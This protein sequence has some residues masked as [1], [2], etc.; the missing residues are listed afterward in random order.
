[1][2]EEALER[3]RIA[4]IVSDGFAHHGYLPVETPLIEDRMSLERVSPVADSPFQLFDGDGRLLMVRSDLTMPIARMVA[5]RFS[6]EQAP[7]RLRYAAPVVRECAQNM[8]RSRQFTQLGIELIGEA[9][10]A[11][12]VE[13]VSLAAESLMKLGLEDFCIACGSVKPMK[14]LLDLCVPDMAAQKSLLACIHASDFIDFEA[15]LDELGL[16]TAQRDALARLPRMCGGVEELDAAALLLA[17]FGIEDGG[18]AEL[19]ELFAQAQASGFADRLM[20]DFSIMNSFDYYTGLVFSIYAEGA[21]DS[22]GSGGRYDEAFSKLGL[23]TLPAAGFA[24]SLESIEEALLGAAALSRPLRI[25]VP[26]GSLFR[27]TVDLLAAAGFDVEPLRN[28]GRHLIV[29]AE[30][31]EYVIVRPTDAPAF[32]ASGGADCGICGR[33]SL[34]EANLD[35][36]QLLDLGYGTCRFVVAEPSDAAGRA[37][38]SYA[39]RG[40]VRVATKYPRITQVYYDKL[41]QQVDIVALHGNIELGP[42]VGMADRIVDITATG[43]TLRENNLVIV[44]DVLECSARFFASPA[45]IR[46][47]ERIRRLAH[48]LAACGK[49]TK[50]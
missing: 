12:D 48:I 43:T 20:L 45:R 18:I 27:E 31:V 35:L 42:L 1:M 22:I 47:D 28:P 16:E 49:G 15:K 40:S 30:G 7:F 8:G 23:G 6:C 17:Q 13:V 4:R 10:V 26:K 25:A 19:R 5:T 34:I 44:D 38:A 39:R 24:L 32:V 46:C 50:E 37:E 3:E 36:V 9:G 33:D 21:A 41:G 29:P 11:A 2:P 14:A